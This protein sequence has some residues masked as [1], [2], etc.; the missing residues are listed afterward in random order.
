MLDEAVERCSSAVELVSALRTRLE[1]NWAG[2]E[3]S[4]PRLVTAQ[5]GADLLAL[6]GY[7][8]PRRVP[9]ADRVRRLAEFQ[10][11]TSGPALR[12]SL[13]AARDVTAAL[14]R[15]A[16]W[17]VFTTVRSFLGDGTR[18][19]RAEAL[20]ED[21]A[22]ALR[23]D[24]VNV[25]LVPKLGELVRGAQELISVGSPAPT[26]EDREV[27]SD[28]LGQVSEEYGLGRSRESVKGAIREVAARL[29]E[30]AVGLLEG[31]DDGELLLKL[32]AS[33]LRRKGGE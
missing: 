14:R 32:E 13:L 12:E 23:A 22:E 29:E 17:L 8:Q 27:T 10:P 9:P 11:L 19:A 33:F 25:R 28:Q 3:A 7:R 5:S 21:L 15:D 2:E 16:E 6:L 18:K 1:Q 31:V 30:R 4:P 26:D 24:Q 20:L